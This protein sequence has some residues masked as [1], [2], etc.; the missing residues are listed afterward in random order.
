MDEVDRASGIDTF[1]NSSVNAPGSNLPPFDIKLEKGQDPEE[2]A[3]LIA[4][5][6]FIDKPKKQNWMDVIDGGSV[7]AVKPEDSKIE[8]MSVEQQKD[9]SEREIKKLEYDLGIREKTG[10]W[11]AANLG[12]KAGA[13]GLAESVNTAL[14]YI[15]NRVGSKEL[16]RIGKENYEFWHK[17]SKEYKM[18]ED[19]SGD[20]LD[21]PSL[22]VDPAF[23]AYT[24]AQTG[25]SMLPSLVV[26]AGGAKAAYKGVKVLGS[27]VKLTP[28]VMKRLVALGGIIPAGMVGGGQEGTG[29]Y[30]EML[31]RGATEEQAARAMEAMT[32]ASGVLNSISFGKMGIFSKLSEPERKTVGAF[33]KKF[34]TSG[35]TEAFTEYAEEPIEILIKHNLLPK[36][37]TKDEIVAQLK[38]GANVIPAAFG[39]GG[40][41]GVAGL[42]M[43]KPE[44]DTDN[45]D[46]TD[47]KASNDED[48]A[49]INNENTDNTGPNA[50]AGSIAIENPVRTIIR[51]A[52]DNSLA[53]QAKTAVTKDSITQEPE[54]VPDW[55][56]VIDESVDLYQVPEEDSV[57]ESTISKDTT[58]DVIV[59]PSSVESENTRLQPEEVETS[60]P[61]IDKYLDSIS[62]EE[63][64]VM[65]EN[66]IL[67]R[68]QVEGSEGNWWGDKIDA[69]TFASV[70]EGGKV[71][72]RDVSGLKLV[73]AEKIMSRPD[74]LGDRYVAT[75]LTTEGVNALV[76]KALAAGYDGIYSKQTKAILLPNNKQLTK[77]KEEKQIADWKKQAEDNGVIF[78]GVQR[79]RNKEI[80]F[81]SFTGDFDGVRSSFTLEA[82]E[83]VAEAI[84]R[85]QEQK[86]RVDKNYLVSVGTKAF[87][88]GNKEFFAWKKEVKKDLGDKWNDYKSLISEAW[89][90]V[91]NERGSFSWNQ[92]T[93]AVKEAA[94]AGKVSE[95]RQAIEELKKEFLY[96]VSG[97][98]LDQSAITYLKS[99]KFE[100]YINN[101]P[102]LGEITPKEVFKYSESAR[103]VIATL[104]D[105]DGKIKPA[106]RKSGFHALQEFED[107]IAAY[108]D[109]S[110]FDRW[111]ADPTRLIQ[112]ADQGLF[113]GVLQKHILWPIRSTVMARL[114]WSD[115]Y[116]TDVM[117]IQEKFNIHG[118]EK[119]ELTGK[120][121]EAIEFDPKTETYDFNA[122]D[123]EKLLS[124]FSDADAQKIIDAA[125]E[126]RVMWDKL[127]S[128]Q[129]AARAKRGDKPI[130]RRTFYR[131][132]VAKV[133]LWS[134]IFG[135]KHKTE[136]IMDSISLP[137][138]SY[139]DKNFNPRAEKRYDALLDEQLEK[140]VVQLMADYIDVAGKDIFYNNIIQNT[141]IHTAVMRKHGLNNAAN[142]I[143]SYVAEAYA[144]VNSPITRVAKSTLPNWT[145]ESALKLRRHLTRAVF[146]LNITW[147]LFIQTSSAGLTAARY[148]IGNSIKG[149]KFFTDSELRS[150]IDEIAYSKVIKERWVGSMAYQDLSA[151]GLTK[152]RKLEGTKIDSGEHYANFLTRAIE[153]GLTGH[154]IVAAYMHGKK[155]GLEG[156][157]LW[158]YASE[159]GAKTQSMYNPEDSVGLLRAREVG[160]L[161]PFQ[162]FAFEMLNSAREL[163]IPG[164]N[165]VIGKTGAYETIAANSAQGKGLLQNRMKILA[166]WFACAVVTNAV[167]DEETGREPWELSSFI[168]FY[169]ILSGLFFDES[170]T[171]GLPTPAQYV[172]DLKSGVKEFYVYGSFKK[173]RRW[174]LRYHMIG[175]TQI[176]RTLSGF[177]ANMRGAVHDAT[178]KELFK[179]EG[180]A[181]AVRSLVAGPWRTKAGIQ[182]WK[183]RE[184]KQEKSSSWKD[185]RSKGKEGN[186]KLKTLDSGNTKKLNSL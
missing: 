114:H 22:I 183:D 73:N 142:A 70:Q 100:D 145:R 143:D 117:K 53:K 139:P 164:I 90:I 173:L 177:E 82:G 29:T 16:V 124:K 123:V 137:E 128:E 51:N 158:E 127:L 111:V 65:P 122:A 174:A 4:K 69:E 49:G 93:K 5:Q 18:P 3:K 31:E 1:S 108:K 30:Q 92:K 113:G 59:E 94:K 48:F 78:E 172:R 126:F 154:A 25:V 155:L 103:R 89:K 80:L 46:G 47:S 13:V 41:G 104:W 119:L 61:R 185:K 175:G 15:G 75:S 66:A 140:N 162:T 37:M 110:R 55:M 152:M 45:G 7:D 20:I 54:D 6:G 95:A 84:K 161:A 27:V 38:S 11:E 144:G 166:L 17:M 163:N 101:M 14:Q 87:D 72:S 186:K 98:K 81:P 12:A 168:P 57:I 165:L 146:P 134:K 63:D 40:F 133:T 74:E 64:I 68:G 36:G 157:A 141:K 23:L 86:K 130:P 26:G 107:N 171:R 60:I 10:A 150:A 151:G 56:D 118:K 50:G 169:G 120:V 2:V 159:G 156:R 88:S 148:G 96:F 42:A 132:H 135:D 176:E 91:N 52:V 97:N 138:M 21:D 76:D 115:V 149:L 125:I 182:Y 112:A 131:P 24:F 106:I 160:A 67:Y 136:S 179:I 83:T 105:K 34:I 184:A 116:K 153:N 121:V 77:A 8:S 167:V 32:T 9:R 99:G 178:G 62:G 19:I 44:V 181:E 102:T 35:A 85:K 58:E 129:N 39:L 109:I 79:G 170:S 33:I 28:K 147:N 71:E 43:K 180:T